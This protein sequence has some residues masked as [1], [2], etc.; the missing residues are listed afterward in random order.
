MRKALFVT[1][2]ALLF[3]GCN[4][5]QSQ[6]NQQSADQVSES[7][8]PIHDFI[9]SLWDYVLGEELTDFTNRVHE[10]EEGSR[11]SHIAEFLQD[12]GMHY[13]VDYDAKGAASV[14]IDI[15]YGDRRG[16]SIRAFEISFSK[17]E[18]ISVKEWN[19]QFPDFASQVYDDVYFR[20]SGADGYKYREEKI[21]GGIDK[22]TIHY[23]VGIEHM[24]YLHIK[25]YTDKNT[26]NE[27]LLRFDSNY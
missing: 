26:P 17:P 6:S 27:I 8:A 11:Y 9:Y 3:C 20:F 21:P 14:S 16:E 15:T 7:Y 10:D 18:N 24:T 13:F 22:I 12:D 23:A 25:E 19:A 1:I 5:Q 2:L 4:Q